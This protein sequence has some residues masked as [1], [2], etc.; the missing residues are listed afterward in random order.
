MHTGTFIWQE[1]F[2]AK[3]ETKTIKA[4]KDRAHGLLFLPLAYSKIL[5]STEMVCAALHQAFQK[6]NRVPA[7]F[8]SVGFVIIVV[9]DYPFDGG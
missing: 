4:S 5:K 1:H 3:L 7:F 9:D 2:A 6:E 8:G